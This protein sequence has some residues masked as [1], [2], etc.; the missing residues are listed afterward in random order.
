MFYK[1]INNL[2]NIAI[3]PILVP[4]VKHNCHYNHIQSL[5]SDAFRYQF[6]PEV[7]DF[8]IS[9]LTIWQLN[10][11][12]SHFAMQPSSGSHPY[13]GTSTQAQIPGAWFKTLLSFVVAVGIVM[14]LIIYISFKYYYS[15]AEC[16]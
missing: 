11:L 4:S 8:G 12:L 6:F 15:F 10:H 5:C 16:V 3:L 13:S 1:L 7:S 14:N 9:F 2:A